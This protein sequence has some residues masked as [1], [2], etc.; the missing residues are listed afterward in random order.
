MT[1]SLQS[2]SELVKPHA[3]SPLLP[4]T[5]QGTPGSVT[6]VRRRDRESFHTIDARYQMFGT[7]SPRCMSLA[8]IA[9]PSAVSRLATAQLLLPRQSSSVG[10]DSQASNA[11]LSSASCR[12]D[13]ACATRGEVCTS[14]TLASGIG[15]MLIT[16]PASG[17]SHS[18]AVL[19]KK[20]ASGFGNALYTAARRDS[21]CAS[22]SC[23]VRNIDA[24]TSTESS[25]VH[26]RGS[27]RR[28]RYS[29]GFTASA[30][31]PALT[32]ST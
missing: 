22:E 19:V 11:S 6:P 32:P 30:R 29:G 9:P 25:T 15:G 5:S 28:R 18:L 13:G 17:V 8:T 26:G 31:K 1:R 4:A 3:T 20:S 27:V 14:N 10:A 21:R 12:D 23:S 2:P 16:L 7:D 24:R